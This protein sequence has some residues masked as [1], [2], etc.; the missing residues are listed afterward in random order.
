L[1][2]KKTLAV[3]LNTFLS[4]YA[5]YKAKMVVNFGQ[6]FGQNIFLA[7]NFWIF[8]FEKLRNFRIFEL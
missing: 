5:I 6:F 1:K 2:T 7:E 4:L 8:V 3:S